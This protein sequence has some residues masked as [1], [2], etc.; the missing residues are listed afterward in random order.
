[1]DNKK[2]EIVEIDGHYQCS[3][4]WCKILLVPKIPKFCPN[5]GVK[6]ER[7]DRFEKEI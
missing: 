2:G 5:C 3:K 1:M 4:C 7:G 6:F